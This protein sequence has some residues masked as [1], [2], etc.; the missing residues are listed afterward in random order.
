[1]CLS[2]I[3]EISLYS[4]V[5]NIYNRLLWNKELGNKSKEKEKSEKL[6]K[7]ISS[8]IAR[9]K[10]RILMDLRG[11]K[12]IQYDLSCHIVANFCKTNRFSM[13]YNEL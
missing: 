1:L 2:V 8:G 10:K 5:I 4:K 3:N 13:D 6:K 7:N 9:G 12:R 11:F